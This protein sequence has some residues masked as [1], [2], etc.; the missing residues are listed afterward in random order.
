[1]CIDYRALNQ[2]TVKDKYSIRLI[3]ELLDELCGAMIFSKL[4]LHYGDHQILVA[5]EDIPKIAFQIHQGHYKFLVMPFG[6]HCPLGSL[7]LIPPFNA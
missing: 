7:M 2:V 6:A 4:D 3:D 1:M 5:P